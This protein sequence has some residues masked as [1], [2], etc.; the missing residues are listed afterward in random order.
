[1]NGLKTP[2]NTGR[3]REREFEFGDED[4]R[5]LRDLVRE[6]TGITLSEAKREL[7]YGRLSR[8]LRVLNLGSFREYRQLLA[9]DQGKDEI[10]DFINAVTTNL[11]S[12]FRE[13]HHFD[14]LRDAF[15]APIVAA[16]ARGQRIRIWS[17]GCS[18]GEE[19]YSIAMTIAENLPDWQRMD[20]KILATDLDTEMVERGQNGVYRE[21][22][23][24]GI[25]AKRLSTWFREVPGAGARHYKVVPELASLI[26]FRRL[27][28]MEPLPFKGPL[29]V[30]F[31]RNVIIYFDKETQRELFLRVAPL[32]RPGALLFLGHSE[33]L[34]KV[35][36]SFSLIGKT[37]YR[38]VAG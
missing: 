6:K 4:F 21:D 25:G 9:S 19:P 31:C 11:T 1:M 20:I 7:V 35:S 17:A 15:L 2:V 33:S 14:Y 29:D 5:S 8:R 34:F 37:I 24:A 23:V 18:S 26:T 30:I 38:R 3:E 28:L 32:Q 16:G 12:F 36:E 27:N 10:G 13:N 22:R